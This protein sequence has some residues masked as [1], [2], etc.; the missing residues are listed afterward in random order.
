MFSGRFQ[1]SQTSDENNLKNV[2][3]NIKSKILIKSY[4]VQKFNMLI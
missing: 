1:L 3:I 2:N 4:I